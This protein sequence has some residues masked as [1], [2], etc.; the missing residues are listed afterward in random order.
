MSVKSKSGFS[1]VELIVVMAII[2]IL[3]AITYVSYT[4]VVK[5][6][7]VASL[8]SDLE[9]AS[10]QLFK[11]KAKNGSFPALQSDIND[12]SGFEASDG[13]SFNY[14]KNIGFCLE[15][16]V[17][18]NIYHISSG[19]TDVSEG[20]CDTTFVSV[21]TPLGD[22]V[23]SDDFGGN[24]AIQT[25]DGGYAM[26]GSVKYGM[27][28][29]S[30]GSM[31]LA[32]YD[33][34]GNL[35]WSKTWG[36]SYDSDITNSLIQ[37]S[38]GGYALTGS[39]VNANTDAE[40]MF[41]AKFSATGEISW[42]KTWGNMMEDYGE[43]L[44]QTSDDGYIVVGNTNSTAQNDVFLTKFDADGGLTWSKTWGAPGN[45][46][47]AYSVV[48]A[49]DNGYVITGKTTSLGNGLYDAFLV[50]FN[51]SGNASWIKTWRIG[52]STSG[53]SVIKTNDGGY[54]VTGLIC[55]TTSSADSDMFLAKFDATGGLAWNKTWDGSNYDEGT[56][57]IQ[58]SDSG[59]VVVGTTDS[60]AN[61]N[62]NSFLAKYDTTGNLAW[63]KTFGGADNTTISASI[64]KTSEG[65]YVISGYLKGYGSPF[66]AKY[67]KDGN[68]SGCAS[69]VCESVTAID[70]NMGVSVVAQALP[71]SSR[72]ITPNSPSVSVNSPSIK[73][74][75]MYGL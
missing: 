19:N 11:Y 14:Y 5:K 59:Y 16:S 61:A 4:G 73:P 6:A 3:A 70:S 67:N 62:G 50:K 1:I 71:E 66:I 60:F 26:T 38:D 55:N 24:Y 54:A 20:K 9:K 34:A 40:D 43:S 8:T 52:L 75:V 44:V 32:K 65:G 56:S 17:D 31:F 51:E 33:I 64:F 58:T 39:I 72:T 30:G 49:N 28:G 36:T 27:G 25:S 7:R 37:T 18:G 22:D 63:S 47:L 57:V 45:N 35:S 53:S 13:V 15:A 41:L 68:I 10:S 12:G 23:Q 2:S 74:Y 42:F 21:W 29:Y 69:P 46:D 48:Q